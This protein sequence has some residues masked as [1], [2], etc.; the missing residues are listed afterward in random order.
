MH[1]LACARPA[2]ASTRQARPLTLSVAANAVLP[3]LG[4]DVS[5]Q[6]HDRVAIGAQLTQLLIAHLDVSAR[7]RL[8][9]LAGERSGLYLGAN[10]HVWYSPLILDV[11]TGAT[12]AELGYE[13]R[14]PTGFTFAVGAGGGVLYVPGHAGVSGRKPRW[15]PLPMLNLRLGRSW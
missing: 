10:L 4:V 5:Y 1:V 6:L 2:H 8:F 9:L 15:D 13:L 11:L 7:A 3:S 14:A 12:T